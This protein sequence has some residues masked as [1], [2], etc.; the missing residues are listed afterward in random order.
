MAE[1]DALGD[2][3]KLYEELSGEEDGAETNPEAIR[4]PSRW[5]AVGFWVALAFVLLL[6]PVL[7]L[8]IPL[9]V[10]IHRPRALLDILAIACIP[11]RGS[12]TADG[13][14][15]IRWFVTRLLGYG[16]WGWGPLVLQIETTAREAVHRTLVATENNHSVV[17]GDEDTVA[18]RRAVRGL[19][20][21]E[22]EPS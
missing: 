21:L 16:I 7:A 6:L 10:L 1:E 19:M 14:H 13:R 8:L 3:E 9:C 17:V 5:C 2:E 22:R 15:A 4:L 20:M 11:C 12:V 18:A